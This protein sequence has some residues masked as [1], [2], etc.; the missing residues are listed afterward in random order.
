MA[1]E[2]TAAAGEGCE[3][4]A[5]VQGA[6]VA[7]LAVAAEGSAVAAVAVPE[8]WE[9]SEEEEALGHSRV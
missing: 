2:E 8:A 9:G 4:G 1:Q 5:A 3:A 7:D 6:G